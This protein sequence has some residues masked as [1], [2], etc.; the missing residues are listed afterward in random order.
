MKQVRQA[1][2]AS[3]SFDTVRAVGLALPGVEATIKYDGS[4]V[5]KVGG[6]FMA[7]LATHRSV[8]PDTLVAEVLSGIVDVKPAPTT[9]PARRARGQNVY[10]FTPQATR[11]AQASVH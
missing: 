7:G 9:A 5:L 10:E 11:R 3:N 6:S 1:H 4:P 8:E 2:T